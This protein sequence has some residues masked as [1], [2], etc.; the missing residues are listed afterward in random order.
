MMGYQR[1]SGGCDKNAVLDEKLKRN[2]EKPR[3]D[4]TNVSFSF[5]RINHG[6]A[7]HLQDY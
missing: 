3:M 5:G 6:M 4:E 1:S 2:Q 7:R